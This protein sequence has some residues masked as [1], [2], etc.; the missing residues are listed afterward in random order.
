GVYYILDLLTDKVRVRL[1]IN[2][3]SKDKNKKI[4]DFLYGRKNDI[5][6]K[7]EESLIWE[8]LGDSKTSQISYST[9]EFNRDDSNN[10]DKA[11]EWHIDKMKKF[12]DSIKD[13][14]EKIKVEMRSK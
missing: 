4:F 14:L 6:N 1:Y 5:E 12:E 10:W 9:N 13:E 2:T 8:R 11:I 3:E 7:F